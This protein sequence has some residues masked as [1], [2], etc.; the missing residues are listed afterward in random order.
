E[1]SDTLW[2]NYQ[3]IVGQYGAVQARRIM[4]TMLRHYKRLVYI[5]TGTENQD[6]YRDYARQV[7]D[8]FELRYEEIKGS[9]ALIRQTLY[10]PW[11][12]N[13]V[14]TP[15]GRTISYLD[16]KAATHDRN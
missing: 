3:R 5:D 11:D 10:G 8:H 9:N 15:P 6:R 4:G 12:K 7:A 16:F 14:V 2:D 13:F 1:V